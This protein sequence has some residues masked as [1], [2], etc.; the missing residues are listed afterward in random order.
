MSEPESTPESSPPP[1]PAPAQPAAPAPKSAADDRVT[2]RSPSKVIF[3]YPTLIAAVIAGLWT[4][5]TVGLGVPENDALAQHLGPGRLFWWTFSINML[6]L[7]FDFTRGS[8]VAL[9]LAFGLVTLGIVLVDQDLGFVRPVQGWLSGI[10]L[11]A[12]PT[13]Y[14][15]FAGTLL[16]V[17]AAVWVYVRFDYWEI[18]HNELL[19]H[20]GFL[21]DVERYPAPEMRM[22]K[23]ITDVFEYVLLGSGRLVLHPR[24]SERATVLENVPFVRS[25]EK[26]IQAMLASFSVTVKEG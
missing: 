13:F 16:L 26:R 3:L 19:H 15:M 9:V 2:I 22:S 14:F 20:H 24:G 7:A 8:F 10:R 17:F 6:V 18:T 11:Y 5:F 25:K 4:L 21:G 1:T 23:E 12:T